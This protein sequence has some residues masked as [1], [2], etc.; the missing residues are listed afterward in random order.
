VA[1]P[2]RP[3]RAAIERLT[4]PPGVGRAVQVIETDERSGERL[5]RLPMIGTAFENGASVP[6]GRRELARSE[7]LTGDRQ[8]TIIAE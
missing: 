7:A 5:E 2:H 4:S 8:Q 6:R 3:V 1:K